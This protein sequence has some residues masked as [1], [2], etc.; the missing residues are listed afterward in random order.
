M[1]AIARAVE[2]VQAAPMRGGMVDL[3]G[4]A[5]GYVDSDNSNPEAVARALA[6][7]A[8]IPAGRHW[9]I[10][11]EMLEL[12]EGAEAFHLEAGRR[13]ASLGFDP[14]VGV[15]ELARALVVGA[16]EKGVR[17]HWFA[18]AAE[19]ADAAEDEVRAEDLLLVKGSRGVG[20]EVVVERLRKDG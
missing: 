3:G 9:A 4:G 16:G 20:L 2:Q 1:E 7:A 12:G 10:L 11:G 6:A 13:A 8:D 18:T 17:T 19:A 15:G 14:V 5:S